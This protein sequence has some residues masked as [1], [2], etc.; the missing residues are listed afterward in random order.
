MRKGHKRRR[1][2][3]VS[4]LT[5]DTSPEFVTFVAS[6]QECHARSWTGIRMDMST[7]SHFHA[8]SYLVSR[9]Q[10]L[11]AKCVNAI[12]TTFTSG[13]TYGKTP[14]QLALLRALPTPIAKELLFLQ[15]VLKH[16]IPVIDLQWH[17]IAIICGDSFDTAGQFL[18]KWTSHICPDR[19]DY[20]ISNM[21]RRLLT[22]LK[23]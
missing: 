3:N 18:I 19:F 9:N 12:Q 10:L 23:N 20:T 1:G 5:Q 14:R 7:L 21:W 15:W 13:R 2:E 4:E 8:S 17:I 16:V 6:M 11:V 22:P